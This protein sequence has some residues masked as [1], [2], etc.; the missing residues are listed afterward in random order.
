VEGEA[1]E[2]LKYLKF[3]V[4]EYKKSLKILYGGGIGSE[5]KIDFVMRFKDRIVNLF[6][7]VC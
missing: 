3:E 2:Y 6:S 5:D 4:S 1:K 7:R